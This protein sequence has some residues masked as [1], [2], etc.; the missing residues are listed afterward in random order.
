MAARALWAHQ[1]L[2]IV[3]LARIHAL[4]GGIAEVGTVPRLL[5]AAGDQR[6]SRD[7]AGTLNAAFEFL[8]RLRTR[9]HVEQ[10]SGGLAPNNFIEP[11]QLTAQDRQNL[12]DIFLAIATQQQV[13]LHAFPSSL[14]R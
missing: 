9:H 7:G 13:L 10:M 6:L 11:G 8:L 2:P 1:A 4:A 5:A 14:T 12:R 3:D